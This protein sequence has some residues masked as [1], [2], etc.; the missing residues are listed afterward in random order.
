[1]TEEMKMDYFT[2]NAIERIT[3]M[4]ETFEKLCCKEQNMSVAHS[5][6]PN[7]TYTNFS[8]NEILRRNTGAVYDSDGTH[9]SEN[10]DI[11]SSCDEYERG[12]S[13]D[14][15]NSEWEEP[16]DLRTNGKVESAFEPVFWNA[17]TL[18]HRNHLQAEDDGY[19][20]SDSEATHALDLRIARKKTPP[21]MTKEIPAWVF[22]TR[23]SDRP[24]AGPRARRRRNGVRQERK[25]TAFNDFQLAQLNMEF[26]RDHYLSDTRRQRLAED[27]NLNEANV[28]IWFQNRRAKLK[29]NGDPHPL[30]LQLISDGLYN[31]KSA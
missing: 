8:V 6:L 27:L 30:A 22:C 23:Y 29:K 4:V 28:K 7:K 10:S 13:P 25:R 16:I 20:S 15:Q 24:S 11:Y 21:K 12:S 19:S 31:H 17:L 5:A 26:E 14:T 3:K 2:S 9:L 1:M 18:A